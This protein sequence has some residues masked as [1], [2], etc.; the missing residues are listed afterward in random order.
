LQSVGS[1]LILDAVVVNT[2]IFVATTGVSPAVSNVTGTSNTTI[3]LDNITFKNV[4]TGVVDGNGTVL[5]PGGQ[6]KTVQ[7]WIQGNVYSGSETDFE[8]VKDTVKGIR[9]SR[10]LLDSS[11]KIFS[12]RRPEYDDYSPS[13]T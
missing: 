7:Q 9:K 10:N 4:T 8:Y 13:R 12:K 11:G 1:E 5:L 6:Q 3:I 2:P